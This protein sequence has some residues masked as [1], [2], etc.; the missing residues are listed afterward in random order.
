MGGRDQYITQPFC[1][2]FRC[3]FTGFL[4]TT[5]LILASNPATSQEICGPALA[6]CD[7]QSDMAC[8]ER[9][10]ACGAYDTVIRTLF[11]EDFAPT[12]DQKYF[13]G[14]SFFGNYVRTRST[15]LQCEM[16]TF[17]RDYLT[18]YLSTLDT[19]FGETGSFGTVRQMKQIYHATQMSSVLADVAGCP[20]SSLT[21]A[22]IANIAR[23]EA[24][25]FSKAVFLDPPTEAADLFQTLVIA[26]RSFVSRA[27]DLE[28][29][30]AL[31]G[32]EIQSAETHLGAIRRIFDEVFGPV[33]GSGTNIVIDT[34]ILD[35]LDQQ[36]SRMLR[37][38][39]IEEAAFA[40]A[41]GGVSAEEYAAIRADTIRAADTYLKHSAFH[42]N[43]IGNLMPTDPAKPFWQLA[44]EVRAENS[45]RQAFDDLAQIMDDW[46]AFGA[47]TGLCALP[48]AAERVWYCR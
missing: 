37:D 24:V 22:R 13:I 35:D 30:I 39:E 21:R 12:A 45:S 40:S 15:A 25:D 14:A 11:V 31:R 34:S 8:L 46:E 17:A 42:I 38:V 16:V 19:Q 2:F 23:R 7:L 26:L 20:E 47:A 5:G 44:G 33:A 29:G 48:G 10:Y 32:I 41:L 43:M 6:T 4:V 28:T 18:D 36:T 27:S 1:D 9:T 3:S